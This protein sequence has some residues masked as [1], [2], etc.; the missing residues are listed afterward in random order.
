M[1]YA[2]EDGAAAGSGAAELEDRMPAMLDM[3]RINPRDALDDYLKRRIPASNT[4]EMQRLSV[5]L[6]RLLGRGA[7]VMRRQL[8]DAGAVAQDRVQP[9]LQESLPSAIE[10]DD[11]GAIIAYGGL[12]L[13][14][15][16]HRLVMDE[17]ELYTWCAFDA[18]FLPEIL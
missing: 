4:R 3:A 14:P 12:S 6:Y 16:L 2:L 1:P 7:P 5:A 9:F 18:L 17:T 15:T 10:F 13:V 8:A 11:R